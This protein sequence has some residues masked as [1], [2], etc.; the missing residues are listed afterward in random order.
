MCLAAAWLCGGVLGL[1][2][3]APRKQVAEKFKPSSEAELAARR[4]QEPLEKHAC[5]AAIYPVAESDW[6][7]VRVASLA[8]RGSSFQTA[9]EALCREADGRRL[10]AI[11]D[12]YYWRTPSGWSAYHELRGTAVRYE[13][14]FTPPTAPAFADI[15]PPQ[16]AHSS[17]EEPPPAG[18][19]SKK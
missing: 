11:V 6:R 15:R 19:S 7:L 16:M 17:D 8:G 14:Q 1:G 12:I 4:L 18:E 3:T 9:L 5:K 10:Q 2:C 13:D